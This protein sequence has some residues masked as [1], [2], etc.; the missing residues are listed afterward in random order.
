VSDCPAVA[1]GVFTRNRVKAA[2]VV[3]CQKRLKRQCKLKA[4]IINSGNANACTGRKGVADA[5]SMAAT[6]AG[7][8]GIS[9]AL[10]LV[11]STGTIG[12]PLPMEKIKI[13]I[14]CAV[15]SLKPDGGNEAARAIMTTDKRSKQVAVRLRIGGKKVTI[16]AMAK[17]AGMI[18]PKMATLLAFIMTDAAIDRAALPEAL[19]SA[20]D[21]SFNRIL[22]DGDQS[23][24][25]TV[26]CFA[27][28]LAGNK[29]LTVKHPEWG[30][31]KSALA[32]VCQKLAYMIVEDGEGVT[33][34]VRLIVKGGKTRAEAEK[35]ARA[36]ARSPLV[37]TSWFGAD[38]NWGRIMCAIG[39]SGAAIAPEKISIDYEGRVAVI[40]GK[41]SGLPPDMLKKIIAGREFTIGIDLHRGRASYSMLTCDC[42]LD[43]VRINADYMT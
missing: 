42:S 32:V 20:V 4:V 26:L 38:P 12:V 36:I 11:C 6:T 13:G 33:K 17:G 3:L 27:N 7:L 34:V 43:Y 25:D 21:T 40:N 19:S 18:S 1:A 16:G 30:V 41:S 15:R 37:K 5:E 14:G 39:Y 10:V 35:V 24:N 31:F 8:L 9:P 29:T 28:G 23:T 2:P 22:I